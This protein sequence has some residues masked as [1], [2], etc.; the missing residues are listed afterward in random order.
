MREK[1]QKKFFSL[2]FVVFF[3]MSFQAKSAFVRQGFRA[4]MSQHIVRVPGGSVF[5]PWVGAGAL[6]EQLA[7]TQEI[8]R[9]LFRLPGARTVVAF[10]SGDCAAGF[11]RARPILPDKQSRPF[12]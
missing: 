5:V 6:V 12:R 1:Y 9:F 4:G 2:L 11:C 10:F 3:G 8:F 7:H